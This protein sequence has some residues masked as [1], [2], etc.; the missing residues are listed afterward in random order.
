MLHF[1]LLMPACHYHCTTAELLFASLFYSQSILPSLERLDPS[2][3]AIFYSPCFSYFWDVAYFFLFQGSFSFL[4][5]LGVYK[6]P[7]HYNGHT[8]RFRIIYAL[9]S[10]RSKKKR[11][12]RP[13]RATDFGTGTGSLHQPIGFIYNKKVDFDERLTVS[14]NSIWSTMFTPDETKHLQRQHSKNVV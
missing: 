14:T 12:A 7:L 11:F 1:T 6:Y 10:P 4:A 13:P 3:L 8:N 2:P 5:Q 9:I